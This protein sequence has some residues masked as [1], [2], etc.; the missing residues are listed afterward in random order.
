MDKD[1]EKYLMNLA[2]GHLGDPSKSWFDYLDW[3]SLIECDELLTDDELEWLND[4]C[5]VTV[6]VTRKDA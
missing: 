4:N 3:D 6:T 5:V 2:Q 1:R